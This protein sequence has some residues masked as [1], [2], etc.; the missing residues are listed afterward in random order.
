[1]KKNLDTF[2]PPSWLIGD[3]KP[4]VILLVPGIC[5]VG[6]IADIVRDRN[7]RFDHKEEMIIEEV[8][9]NCVDIENIFILRT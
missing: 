1:M 5:S 3:S 8:S 7:K 2:P 9:H 6:N 4:T